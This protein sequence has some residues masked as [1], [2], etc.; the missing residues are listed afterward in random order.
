M[1]EIS[2]KNFEDAGKEGQYYTAACSH[3]HESEV[4]LFLDHRS[5]RNRVISIF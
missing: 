1:S 2:I 5:F 3:I 4:K